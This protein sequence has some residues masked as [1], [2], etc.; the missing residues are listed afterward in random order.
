MIL[1]S[2][3]ANGN[4]NK[5]LELIGQ[6]LRQKTARAE[7]PLEIDSVYLGKQAIAQCRGCRICFDRGEEKCPL[8]DDLLGIKKKM[9]AADALI[10]A[11]PVYVNDVSGHIKTWMDRLA[12]V[13]HRPEFA[14]KY[15]YLL[16]TSGD[17]PANHALKTLKMALNQWGFTIAGQS[18][19]T[20]GAL[21]GKDEARERFERRCERIAM[22]LLRALHQRKAARPSFLSLMTFKIQ[23]Q[24]W[25]LRQ[26]DPDVAGSIDYAYWKR[27]GWIDSGR[28]YFYLHEA[29]RL[30][31]ALARMSGAIL[32]RYVT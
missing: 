28:D 7:R 21:M 27:Q 11:T 15:A 25:Q 17:G 16:A 3:R 19:F 18:A 5:I 2:N 9:L 26:T 1:G 8:K 31:V 13:N 30:K 6:H 22:T 29:S 23:Q 10:V 12:H 14:G 20:M 24:Y 4:T 32:A